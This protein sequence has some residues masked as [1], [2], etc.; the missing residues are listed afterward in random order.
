M[1][2]V[3]THTS[4]ETKG[5]NCYQNP[6]NFVPMRLTRIPASR[7]C[8]G[9]NIHIHTDYR[10]P[11][12]KKG[13]RGRSPSQRE[14]PWPPPGQAFIVFLGTLHRG[15]S[16]FT[17]HRFTTGD[18]LLRRTKDRTLLIS[19]KRRMLQLEG[20][21]AHPPY[22]G[23]LAQ[24]LGRWRYSVNICCLNSGW[25]SFSNS[26]CHS[27]WGTM[28][29]W[30]PT[31]E[32]I[33]GRGSCPPTSLPTGFSEWGLSHVSHAWNSSPHLQLPSPPLGASQPPHCLPMERALQRRGWLVPSS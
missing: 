27:S 5:T 29:A 4:S 18:Y 20:E 17:M 28:Q 10:H 30:F 1:I 11:V 9:C 16:S 2:W 7:I 3:K 6:G 13:L 25:G 22:L 33:H 21:A 31:G 12:E 23:G 15:R 14:G 19:S 32:P 24:I 8:C 26:K